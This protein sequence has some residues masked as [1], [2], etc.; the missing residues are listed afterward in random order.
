MILA[1]MAAFAAFGYVQTGH[2]FGAVMYAF[3][4]GFPLGIIAFMDS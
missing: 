2:V 1:I 4:C 3:I